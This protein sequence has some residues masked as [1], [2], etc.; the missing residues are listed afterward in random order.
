MLKPA[1]RADPPF[2]ADGTSLDL[3]EAVLGDGNPG[4]WQNPSLP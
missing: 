2:L 1:K 3:G 4:S